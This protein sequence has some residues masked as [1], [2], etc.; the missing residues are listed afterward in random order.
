MEWIYIIIIFLSFIGIAFFIWISDIKRF[1]RN[2]DVALPYKKKEY[3]MTIAEREF[4]DVLKEVIKD[5]YYIIPQVVISDIV[6]VSANRRDYYK[7]RSKIDK[8]RIDFVLFSKDA[9][10]PGIAIELDDNSHNKENRINRDHFVDSVMRQVGIKIVHIK[11]AY[12]YNPEEIE[13][14]IFS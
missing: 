14:I 11:T 1:G 5:K 9:L 12:K 10:T 8:K 7:Y 2:E 6:Y 13:K 3:L 4:F